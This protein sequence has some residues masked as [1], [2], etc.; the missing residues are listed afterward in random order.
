MHLLMAERHTSLLLHCDLDVGLVFRII[1]FVAYLLFI[2]G[3]C[4]DPKVGVY[5]HPWMVECR[6][7]FLAHCDLDE[8][9][10]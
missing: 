2:L 4:T 1:V 5:M 3:T 8:L 9:N 10:L 6:V 7:Y